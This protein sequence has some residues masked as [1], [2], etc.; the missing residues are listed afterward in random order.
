[1][2]ET[3]RTVGSF[4]YTNET[5][6]ISGPADYMNTRFK[7]RMTKIYAGQ[8]SVVNYGLSDGREI[9]SLVLV[10]LQTDYASFLGMKSFGGSR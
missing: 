6:Q 3:T 7:D 1:M 2:T 9:I 10:S 5:G 4:I 8:D